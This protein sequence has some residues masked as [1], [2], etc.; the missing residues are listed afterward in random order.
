MFCD[1]LRLRSTQQRRHFPLPQVLPPNLTYARLLTFVS[2]DRISLYF[3][4]AISLILV[5]WPALTL[6]VN[7]CWGGPDSASKRDWL[8]GIISDLF[9]SRPDVDEED[10]EDVLAQVLG[11]EFDVQLED[12]SEMEVAAEICAM[13]RLTA[14]GDFGPV[15]EMKARW[16][17]RE[18]G[19]GQTVG[20]T[21]GH[22]T[23]QEVCSSEEEVDDDDNEDGGVQL[24]AE[25]DREMVDVPP[26][27]RSEETTKPEVDEEG[28]T[29][30]IGKKRR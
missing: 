5:R 22:G 2:K 25:D 14:R 4:L 23:D 18:K 15:E 26:L 1:N 6:A 21:K 9:A 12:G 13:R 3:D 20:I 7:N 28:F 30:V 27:A 16:E 29:K 17:Q 24:E 11:D 10:V 19:S 8:G